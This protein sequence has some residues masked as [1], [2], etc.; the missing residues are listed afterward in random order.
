M[1][2]LVTA[3]ISFPMTLLAA[4]LYVA[5]APIGK[6]TNSGTSSD[7]PLLSITKAAAKAKP[8]DVVRVAPGTYF[9]NVITSVH[10]RSD[11]RIRFL[12]E[13]KWGAKIIGSGTGTMWNNK[14]NFVDIEGFDISGSGRI[15]IENNGSYVLMSKNHIHDL[16]V[17]GGCNG[18]GGAGIVNAN[19]S[20]SDGDIIGNVVHDIGV[21]GACL[22]VQGI[23]YSNFRGRILNNIVYRVS[24]FGIHLWHAANNVLI[25][26]N[27]VFANGSRAMGGGIVIG[28]GDSPGGI[29]LDET[30]VINNIVVYN[31][32]GSIDQ[33]CNRNE[34]CIGTK[35]TTANNLVFG[36]GLGIKLRKG[37]ATGTIALN[38]LF[39]NSAPQ[40]YGD[41]KLLSNSPAIDKGMSGGPINDYEGTVRDTAPDIGAYEFKTPAA[42]LAQFA[43]SAL[44]FDATFVGSASNNKI[45][46]V[47][48]YGSAPLV[49]SSYRTSEG[50]SILSSSTCFIGKAYAPGTN[51]VLQVA[52]APSAPGL[53]TGV[54]EVSSNNRPAIT[55][56]ALS[57]SGV[58]VPKV[59]RVS[60]STSFL[61]FGSV[62]VGSMSSPMI[63]TVT[64][65][66]TAPL[67]FSQAFA[68][69]GDFGFAGSGTCR[70]NTSY[71][72]G[73][74]CTASVAFKPTAAGVRSGSLSIASNA[75]SA[76]S[77][78]SL[79]G[80][81]VT[82]AKP[83]V[84]LSVSSLNF[85]SVRIGTK[86]LI[87]IVT[88][89]N[90]GTA[91]LIFSQ[92]FTMTGKFSFGGT[93]TCGV[94]VAY[95][96][97]QSCTASVVFIPTT[98]GFQT[99]ALNIISNADARSV[100]LSGSG[101]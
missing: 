35:N 9:E 99:G 19:Y 17:S 61:N 6:A 16:K 15:G 33:Y 96:P 41:F 55:N 86:S 84:T 39:V 32:R 58:E 1:K 26:N 40:T 5:P 64:N 74:S 79:S 50:F 88:I 80:T 95:Y 23:Y 20:A 101:I 59:P 73:Q 18:G 93:G 51:C 37:I 22:G 52:F 45:V 29:V 70:M 54:L 82:P 78:V 8:G 42:P 24:A 12:S 67:V 97:G 10:G 89:T 71:A 53:R 7:S 83:V 44:S 92:G 43:P 31:P 63:V 11:A 2:F 100:S 4:N 69:A 98:L 72:P 77:V 28:A 85:G 14:G 3:M 48:N 56:I 87:R 91:P 25:S 62:S 57:G 94:N 60:L 81:G 13:T 49:L 90:S 75:S 66:G 68:M 27:T 30:K 38:P 47:T 76:P 36:N 46:T 65:S 21:P 34:D